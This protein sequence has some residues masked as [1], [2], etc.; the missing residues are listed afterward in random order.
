MKHTAFL[1]NSVNNCVTPSVKPSLM[2]LMQLCMM[3]SLTACSTTPKPTSKASAKVSH[4]TGHKHVLNKQEKVEFGEVLS[5]KLLDIPADALHGNSHS[6]NHGKKNTNNNVLN[7]VG[8]TVGS[9][10]YRSI[11][12]SIDIATLGGLFGHSSNK[13]KV[14]ELIIKKNT[15]ET[16]SITQ[17]LNPQFKKGDNI[18]ILSRNGKAHVVR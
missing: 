1:K 3:L 6:K 11:H 8:I 4:K 15:G 13:H 14:Q 9:G 7:N 17:T 5:V 18:K 12:G 2:L 10:G 16:V